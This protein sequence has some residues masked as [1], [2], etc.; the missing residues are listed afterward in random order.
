MEDIRGD[1][2]LLLGE[3]VGG[4]KSAVDKLLPLVY[5][6]LHR[7]A[8]ACFQG[9]ERGNTLQPTALIHEAYMRLVDTRYRGF[10]NRR[11]FIAFAATLMR[12]IL[13]DHAREK[14][15]Q[16]RGGNKTALDESML[17]TRVGEVDVLE[18]DQALARLDAVDADQCRVVELRYFGGLSIRETA[19]ALEISEPTVKRRWASARA[20]LRREMRGRRAVSKA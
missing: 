5:D 10:E 17:V 6:E 2:T 14:R 12:R 15:A 18:L 13:V 3:M 1:V 20:W 11:Q 4:N 7:Q 8:L 19:Q 16:K 9:E